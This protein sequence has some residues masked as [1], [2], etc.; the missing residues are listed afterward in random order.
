MSKFEKLFERF[1][2][3]PND[4]SYDELRSML[5][6]F[7]YIEDNKGKTSGSR[8]ALI[9]RKTKHIMRLHRPHPETI[10]KKYQ[11]ALIYDELKAQGVIK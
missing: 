4:F 9:Q 6:G 11:M 5:K 8:V 10:L 3:Q 7:D 1:C 2:R